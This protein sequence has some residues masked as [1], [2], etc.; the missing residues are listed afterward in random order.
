MV[1]RTESR[2]QGNDTVFSAYSGAATAYIADNFNATTGGTI[3][4]WLM[5]PEVTIQNG[6]TI[7]FWTRTATGSTYPDRLELR[8][9]LNGAS[10]NC[11][12]LPTDVGDF[13]NLL[14]EV[15]PTLAVGGY[16]ETWTQFSATVSGV[17][18]ATNGRFALRYFVTDAG[19]VG[20]NSSYIG[21]D[22]ME[23]MIVPVELQSFSVE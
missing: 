7:S 21:V 1:P 16:P 13:T 23:Y 18:S 3:S 12:S 19:P 2:F 9:S 14:I 10:T 4:D 5:T 20:T 15:N 22:L 6:D 17:A 8:M 11:G